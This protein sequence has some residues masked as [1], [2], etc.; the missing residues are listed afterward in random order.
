M[1]LGK[2]H[3]QHHHTSPQ[4]TGGYASYGDKTETLTKP[5]QSK[6]KGIGSGYSSLPE[7][8]IE[9]GELPRSD[10]MMVMALKL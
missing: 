7:K 1:M 6:R 4:L 9:F 2:L 5:D 10:L 3:H 8:F